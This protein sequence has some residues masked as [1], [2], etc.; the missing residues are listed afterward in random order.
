MLYFLVFVMVVVCGVGSWGLFEVFSCCF[1][2]LWIGCFK[3]CFLCVVWCCILVM[4]WFFGLFVFWSGVIV[5]FL[6]LMVCIFLVWRIMWV[7]LVIFFLLEF[8][9]RLIGSFFFWLLL[10]GV[11][12][13]WYLLY[14][15]LFGLGFLVGFMVWFV[16]GVMGVVR[17]LFSLIII[18]VNFFL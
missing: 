9:F 5:G 12:G 18:W 15:F 13:W 16:I 4:F 17:L 14:F 1:V 11:F 3:G 2:D 10:L 6:S 8:D 7:R